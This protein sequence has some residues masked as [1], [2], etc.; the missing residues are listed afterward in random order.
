MLP[1][2]TVDRVPAFRSL[3]VEL[4]SGDPAPVGVLRTR[5]PVLVVE[6]LRQ[7]VVGSP[8]AGGRDVQGLP[9]L[10]VSAGCED[11]DVSAPTL[12]PV[13]DGGP[14]VTVF[15]EAGP[16]G[17]LE[18]VHGA[19]DL[20]IGR[21]VLGS[22]RQDSG[23]VFPFEG[24]RVGDQGHLV[25]I[26]AQH[27]DPRPLDASV[28]VGPE[29]VGGRRARARLSA[30]E[31]NEHRYS[32]RR[33]RGRR[34][35]ADR[36]R[37]ITASCTS[38]AVASAASLWVFTH[39]ATWLTFAPI[40]PTSRIRA[41]ISASASGDQTRVRSIAARISCESVTPAA[42]AFACHSASSRGVTRAWAMA[43]RCSREERRDGG[44]FEGGAAGPPS[45]GAACV[46]RRG[47]WLY[48]R[49]I[50]GG[51]PGRVPRR[52]RRRSG[53]QSIRERF[54]ALPV[55]RGR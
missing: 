47:N 5:P 3:P 38:T 16:R 15:L 40:R 9:R 33:G 28:V 37:S 1:H 25:R 55:A 22:P 6:G 32:P 17:A 24:E 14:G 7:R 30:V 46:A 20:S 51:I 35:T 4:G 54:P 2:R 44:G 39:R 10:Q 50:P 36:S 11:V 42:S 23:A 34:S 12:L 41:R 13:E 53:R 8:P 21:P 49:L 48:P 29:K 31:A 18:L 45:P 19:V 52:K 27:L 43:V 26:P